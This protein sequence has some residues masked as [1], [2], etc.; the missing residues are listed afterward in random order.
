MS[1]APEPFK[2]SRYRRAAVTCGILA[3]SATSPGDRESLLRMQQSWLERARH[4]DW[5]SELPPDP[6]DRS[7]ALARPRPS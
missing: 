5:L 6:P 1:K 4:E 2:G 3:A 7:N